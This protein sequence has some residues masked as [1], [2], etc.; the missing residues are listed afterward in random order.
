MIKLKNIH[1]L[2]DFV[3]NAKTHIGKL[4]RS[5]EPAILTV[6]GEAEAVVLSA[7]AYEALIE[8]YETEKTQNI[9]GGVMLEM[10]R[11]GQV[12]ADELKASL[13]PN[14]DA[15]G[16]PAEEAFSQMRRRVQQRRR[17]KAS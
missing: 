2:S 16:L 4:K 15:Q 14:P 9:A 7:E 3:R 5:G 10:L 17:K 1:P 11:T 13:K 6:N 8:K 12:S